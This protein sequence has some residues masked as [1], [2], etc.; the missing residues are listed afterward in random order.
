M[1]YT[2]IRGGLGNQL[3]QYSAARSLADNLG[4]SLELDISEYN[5]ISPFKMSLNEF[6]V[7]GQYFTNKV[8]KIHEGTK[9]SF[10]YN[11]FKKN[12]N[13]FKEHGLMFDNRLFSK[14]DETY[15]KGYW[16]SEKYFQNNKIDI[17]KDLSFSTSPNKI[18]KHFLNEINNITSV[19]LHIRRGD[20]LSNSTYNN[21]Y[22]ICDLTYYYK[23]IDY[24]INQLGNN[25]KV[26]IFSDDI[27]WVSKNFKLPVKTQIIKHNSSQN[28]HEDLRLMSNCKHN[29]IANSSFSWWGA[30]LNK[31]PNKIVIAPKKWFADKNKNNP[32]IL[33][34]NWIRL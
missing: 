8:K 22:G 11:I 19:S 34:S 30:W 4:V 25:I 5:E 28:S 15:L 20:Y 2:R 23:A 27:Y 7:R 17:L 6:N 32:D 10:F 12:K 3:F 13:T 18:N 21:I 24:L 33:P 14:P 1:I 16:Q 9:K 29:I 31:Y 26:F